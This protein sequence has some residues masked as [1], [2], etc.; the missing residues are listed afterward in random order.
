MWV[1]FK[2][3]CYMKLLAGVSN[4]RPACQRGSNKTAVR[5][6]SI[7]AEVTTEFSRMCVTM[8]HKIYD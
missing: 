2:S 5:N 8:K 7:A 1:E 6:L 3:E 4:S